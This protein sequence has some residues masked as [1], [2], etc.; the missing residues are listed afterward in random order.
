MNMS[1]NKAK[2]IYKDSKKEYNKGEAAERAMHRT[3]NLTSY[4]FRAPSPLK[5]SAIT[6]IFSMLVG[7]IIN[8]DI[9]N[10]LANFSVN[11]IFENVIVFGVGLIGIP[12]ILSGF[13]STPTA[14]LTG[15][16]FYYRRSFLLAFISS[17]IIF[18]ILLIGKLL[19]IWF[20]INMIIILIFGYA[21]IISLRHSVLMATSNHK[22]LSSLPS[23]INQSIFGFIFIFIMA[24]IYHISG[25]DLL[26]FMFW[27]SIIFIAATAL[28]LHI[29]AR[30]FRS[31]FGVNG[32]F[33]M[34]H[35]LTQFTEQ[36]STGL[37]LE[38]EFFSK[39]GTSINVRLGT[40]CIRKKKQNPNDNNILQQGDK[41]IG[42]VDKLKTLM[43][44]PS[45]H[46][47][48]FGILGGSNL[49]KKLFNLLKDLTTN[50]MVFHGPVTHDHDPVAAGECRKV[51]SAT[52]QLVRS[53]NYSDS[54]STFQRAYHEMNSEQVSKIQTSNL[55]LCGQRFGN[56]T[57]YIHT[58]SPEST[59]DI[60]YPVG[61]AIIQKAQ[62]DTKH[63]AL[64]I[65]AHN[66]LEP[67]TGQIYYG[68]K[69][70]NNMIKLVSGLNDKFSDSN[71]GILNCGF[72]YDDNFK[73]NQG[74]GPMGIQVLAVECKSNNLKGL[75]NHKEEKNCIT[76]IY[77][78][79]D[80]NNILPGLR[81][82][83]ITSLK[84]LVDEV[85]IFTTDNHVVNATMG[86]YNPVGLKVDPILIVH[87]I[88]KLVKEAIIDCEP[89]E[90]GVNSKIV[91][92][93]RILGQN[94][95]LRLS[96]TINATISIMRSSLIACQGLAVLACVAVV[97]LI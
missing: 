24:D 33:L 84:G 52:R 58:S 67:G 10:L 8:F 87:G 86:G 17:L 28:W 11:N 42:S 88:R 31:N 75:K 92:N 12:A 60:D 20:E 62:H 25:F 40:I 74:I 66:C 35:A 95:P 26:Y 21:I 51:A 65:D 90:V 73:I 48:P 16:I 34:R 78:L 79:I 2:K 5:V 30:P 82:Q 3:T 80:G 37:T 93:I 44:I 18:C 71:D 55:N 32:L 59:D 77:V 50:L 15:G 70:A 36:K 46:P 89:C 4:V 85:E 57:V 38:K 76:N 96:A 64:F 23:S 56:G 97:L 47:G 54:V 14:Y 6:I 81:E 61:E 19:T 29:I 69:K 45:V 1:E 94:T 83:I 13:I 68:S 53:T 7:F 43:V 63:R 22:H 27:F 72:A 49:P 9:G 91:K 39:I 41:K